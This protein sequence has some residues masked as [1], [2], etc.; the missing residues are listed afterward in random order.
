MALA[1]GRFH[2][3]R[4]LAPCRSLKHPTQMAESQNS[5]LADE[6]G[7]IGQDRFGSLFCSLA[8]EEVTT[9]Q[10]LTDFF[11]DIRTDLGNVVQ[12]R[13]VR[14]GLGAFCRFRRLSR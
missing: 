6:A 14:I 3:H 7:E 1:A 4:R 2:L 13:Q 10:T 9:I 11:N 5:S 12:G 8:R